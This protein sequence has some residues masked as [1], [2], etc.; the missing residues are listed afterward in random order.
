MSLRNKIIRLAHQKPELR[1]H[2]LP[3]VKE[4]N[5]TIDVR[6]YSRALEGKLLKVIYNETGLDAEHPQFEEVVRKALKKIFINF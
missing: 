5:Q 3:L 4:S 2:L 6:K 1:K